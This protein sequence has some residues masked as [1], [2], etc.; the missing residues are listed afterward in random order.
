MSGSAV[1]RASSNGIGFMRNLRSR[2]RRSRARLVH[3]LALLDGLQHDD[4]IDLRRLD[5]D[6]LSESITMSAS[7]PG[8][9]ERFASCSPNCSAPQMVIIFNASWGVT[10]S[11]A[12]MIAPERE[13]RF[14]VAQTTCIK[15][16]SATGASVWLVACRPVL[17]IERIGEICAAFSGPTISLYQSPH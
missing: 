8:T 3:G 15:F 16:G 9:S 12:P 2:T 4:R 6:G 10:R 13:M 5:R 14:T 11:S 1:P 7:L 17:R